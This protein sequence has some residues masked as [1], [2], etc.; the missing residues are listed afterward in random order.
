MIFVKRPNRECKENLKI[1]NYKF[2]IFLS[3]VLLGLRT[4]QVVIYLSARFGDLAAHGKREDLKAA[5]GGVGQR[6]FLCISSGR[7]IS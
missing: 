6:R 2:L 7:D 5:A 1:K 3:F 4:R